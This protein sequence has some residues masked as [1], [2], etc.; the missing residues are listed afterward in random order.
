LEHI[1]QGAHSWETP[2]LEVRAEHGPRHIVLRVKRLQTGLTLVVM[3]DRY[4]APA[5]E[6]AGPDSHAR[7]LGNETDAASARRIGAA[8]EELR[9]VLEELATSREELQAVGEELVTLDREN[10]R[11]VHELTQ[12]SMDL[13]H[14]LAS[15]GIATLFLDRDLKI[16]RFTPLL[17]ELFGLR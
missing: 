9:A 8:S 1:E 11:R 17:G 13:Q 10:Q 5:V 15:T 12:V 7:S 3:D 6:A 16:V 4:P 14:L 2:A